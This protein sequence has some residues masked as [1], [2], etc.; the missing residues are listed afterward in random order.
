MNTTKFEWMVIGIVG[1][2]TVL[3]L[4]LFAP[5]LPD[6]FESAVGKQVMFTGFVADM[7]DVRATGTNLTVIPQN[8]KFSVLVRIPFGSSVAYGDTVRVSGVLQKPE[9]FMTNT[10]RM[11]DYEKYLQTENIYYILDKASVITLRH[12]GNI[13]KKNLFSVRQKF[14][15]HLLEVLP[16]E[17]GA[18]A[19]GL[20]L[21][22]KGGFSNELRNDFVRTGTIHIVALSG[23]NITI[24]AESILLIAKQFLSFGLAITFGILGIILFVVM[25]GMQASAVRAGIMAVMALAAKY[26]GRPYQA[27]R[28]LYIA[29]LLMI[30]INPHTLYN[31]SFQ[32]SFL[33][34][35]GVIAVSPLLIKY[36]SSIPIRF[37]LREMVATTLG[38]TVMV[39]PLI[40]YATGIFS[41]ISLLVNVL[42][43]PFIPLAMFLSFFT[44]ALAWLS[45]LLALPIAT[46]TNILLSALLKIITWSSSLPFA[47]FVVPEFSIFFVVLIYILILWWVFKKKTRDK[48]L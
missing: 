3:R 43:L 36:L 47:A 30:L 42:I 38:A 11:F 34:T 41:I 1:V 27:L 12:G 9:A 13:L 33:A 31:I 20:I 18:L 26:S 25:T 24:V 21:G 48:A 23:Y 15:E 32:L 7:P 16:A 19:D 5:T 6:S 14:E 4:F 40:I 46:L 2:L 35:F 39:L 28:A 37:G 17:S 8:Q 29:A 22:A 44:G 45:P 10:G